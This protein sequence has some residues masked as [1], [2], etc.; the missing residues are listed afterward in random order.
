M[1]LKKLPTEYTTAA[2]RLTRLR[3]FK[4]RHAYRETLAPNP[5]PSI[6]ALNLAELAST[7]F[8]SFRPMDPIKEGDPRLLVCGGLA[9]E[10]FQT[11]RD[12]AI[13]YGEIFLSS[14][15]DHMAEEL[16]KSLALWKQLTPEQSETIEPHYKNLQTLITQLIQNIQQAPRQKDDIHILGKR[17]HHLEMLIVHSQWLVRAANTTDLF[18][19]SRMDRFVAVEASLH[20]VVSYWRSVNDWIKKVDITPNNFELY[21]IEPDITLIPNFAGPVTLYFEGRFRADEP[22]IE[23]VAVGTYEDRKLSVHQVTTTSEI[24]TAKIVANILSQK[25][26]PITVPAITAPSS[27]P[28]KRTTRLAIAA[29]LI[30]GGIGLP[31]HHRPHASP[32]SE[33]IPITSITPTP[34]TLVHPISTTSTNSPELLP[35]KPRPHR[36]HQRHHRNEH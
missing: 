29:A 19:E 10:Q 13:F 30:A 9:K 5:A 6:K 12:L 26:L 25:R 36:S 3:A 14:F 33:P 2:I 27:S 35:K 4:N 32:K 24:P 16:R 31:A 17:A 11:H 28:A 15:D 7:L 22:A 18:I 23:F 8:A 1:S 20:A 34:I 21:S